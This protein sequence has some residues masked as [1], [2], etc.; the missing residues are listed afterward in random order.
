[1]R[2]SSVNLDKILQGLE[3]RALTSLSRMAL[4]HFPQYKRTRSEPELPQCCKNRATSGILLYVHMVPRVETPE[5]VIVPCQKDF[6]PSGEQLEHRKL[7]HE[8]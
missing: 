6:S 3:S 5:G 4:T 8:L 7:A 1:M 2:K